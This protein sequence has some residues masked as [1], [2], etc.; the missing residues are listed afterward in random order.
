MLRHGEN[1]SSF[2]LLAQ[3]KENQWRALQK[4]N[5]DA[6]F[7]WLGHSLVQGIGHP[8][9]IVRASWSSVKTHRAGKDIEL[10]SFHGQPQMEGI[11]NLSK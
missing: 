2:F 9:L 11:H 8:F 5:R 7:F 10:Q 1:Q 6:F 4:R 3:T